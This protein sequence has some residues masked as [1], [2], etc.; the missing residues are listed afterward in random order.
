M[1]QTPLQTAAQT[2]AY[3]AAQMPEPTDPRVSV[4]LETVKDYLSIERWED[5]ALAYWAKWAGIDL[6]AL[7]SLV[8]GKNAAYGNAIFEPLR[9]F[10]ALPPRERILL[11]LDNKASR[12]LKGKPYQSEN[13]L[14]DFAGYL[15]LLCLCGEN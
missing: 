8:E 5:A 2:A 9:M 10:S 7:Q 14:M 15:L 12:L 13:D 1:T 4:S 6:A 3:L 11:Q